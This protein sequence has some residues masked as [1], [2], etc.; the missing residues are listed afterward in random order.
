MGCSEKEDLATVFKAQRAVKRNADLS[1]RLFGP[2]HYF[3][4]Y[5]KS[6]R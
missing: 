3:I 5:L 2:L 4:I 6:F 1:M